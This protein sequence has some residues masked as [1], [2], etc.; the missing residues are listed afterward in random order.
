MALGDDFC[1]LDGSRRA[2][3]R[4]SGPHTPQLADKPKFSHKA[5][6]GAL[7]FMV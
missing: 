3:I 7:W 5:K 2:A 4:R 6:V 1:A